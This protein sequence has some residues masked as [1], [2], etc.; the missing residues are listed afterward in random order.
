[1]RRRRSVTAR[2]C[3][4]TGGNRL[5]RR[6]E[7]GGP[8]DLR[9][10][11]FGGPL[12]SRAPVKREHGSGC[13]VSICAISTRKLGGS[14]FLRAFV[15]TWWWLS[16]GGRGEWPSESSWRRDGAALDFFVGHHRK[17][18]V[19]V[20]WMYFDAWIIS[21]ENKNA[22]FMFILIFLHACLSYLNSWLLFL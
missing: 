10:D 8:D 2:A 11:D 15:R 20:E 5:Y 12:F 22:Y 16:A 21:H 1:M 4:Y 7:Q 19:L 3:C 13:I 17:R 14:R 6:A 9:P 18:I